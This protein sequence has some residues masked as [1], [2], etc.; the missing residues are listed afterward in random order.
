MFT[1]LATTSVSKIHSES[2]RICLLITTSGDDAFEKSFT[3]SFVT[4]SLIFWEISTLPAQLSTSSFD[5]I[6]SVVPDGLPIWRNLELQNV[7]SI[8]CQR[9][10]TNRE[11]SKKLQVTCIEAVNVPGS[12]THSTMDMWRHVK[13]V[14]VNMS[15]VSS[16]QT[17]LLILT[18]PEISRFFLVI[19]KVPSTHATDTQLA[20]RKNLKLPLACL[21]SPLYM[22]HHSCTIVHCALCCYQLWNHDWSCS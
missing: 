13:Y 2:P 10:H 6:V 17:W 7:S 20:S 9:S 19:R 21:R 16:R 3:A 5:K 8:A 4:R 14:D 18:V 22:L 12:Q 15:A 11:V 1:G